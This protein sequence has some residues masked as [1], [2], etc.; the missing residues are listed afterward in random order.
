MKKT[1]AINRIIRILSTALN[2]LLAVLILVNGYFAVARLLRK[3]KLPQLWGT[4]MA[5][6]LSDSMHGALERGDVLIIR[7]RETYIPGDII[8]Y[9]SSSGRSLVTHRIVDVTENG[10][11]ITKGDA[12]NTPDPEEVSAWQVQGRTAAVIPKLG[13]I[14]LWL[15]GPFGPLLLGAVL[16]VIM[17]RVLFGERGSEENETAQKEAA[18]R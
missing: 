12:N 3:E 14:S 6:V 2:V 9:T 7:S 10:K 8:T 13:L 1:P 11:F 15:R 18:D 5:I 16:V 4:S 17:G